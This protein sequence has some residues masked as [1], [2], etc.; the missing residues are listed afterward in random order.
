MIDTGLR[1]LGRTRLAVIVNQVDLQYETDRWRL[2][3]AGTNVR[4][5][6]SIIDGRPLSNTVG[7]V[8]DPVISLRHTVRI[9]PGP[10]HALFFHHSRRDS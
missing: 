10:R 8:L 5:P 9:P 2:S 3:G 7:S 4:N 6:V 1:T